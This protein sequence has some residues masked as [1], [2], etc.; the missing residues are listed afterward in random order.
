V[1]FRETCS[2]QGHCHIDNCQIPIIIKSNAGL[3][4]VIDD[5]VVYQETPD[6]FKEFSK[7]LIDM[8]ISI[9]GGCCGITPDHIRAIR[10][11]ADKK[12]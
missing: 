1:D 2:K 3:P 6:D 11:S 10:Q 7:T 4:I 12:K 8:G 9:R 5:N